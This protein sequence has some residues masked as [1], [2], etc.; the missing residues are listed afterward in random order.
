[1]NNSPVGRKCVAAVALAVLATGCG[2]G[3]PLRQE[4]TQ[5]G[6]T[7][8][9]N[10]LRLLPGAPAERLLTIR[11]MGRFRVTCPEGRTEVSFRHIGDASIDAVVDSTARLARAEVVHPGGL[12]VVRSRRRAARQEW[13]LGIGTKARVEVA[14]VS[15]A[16]SPGD[17][18][19]VSGGCLVSAQAV[20]ARRAH[21]NQAP[22]G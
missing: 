5:A 10:D 11:G 6:R 2:Q 20:V 21:T 16:A 3:G 17:L 4:A 14:D 7:V 9:A 19:G 8:I 1:M 12:I 22:S 13:Q 18:A 15:I